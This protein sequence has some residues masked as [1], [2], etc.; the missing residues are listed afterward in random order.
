MSCQIIR[1]NEDVRSRKLETRGYVKR[2]NPRKDEWIQQTLPSDGLVLD[3]GCG[4]G[5]NAMLASEKGNRVIGI[6]ISS[7]NAQEA[8]DNGV[9]VAV[10]NVESHLPTKS[11][12]F[13]AVIFL[14]VVEHLFEPYQTLREIE[15]CL[16]PGG[17]LLI[18]TPNVTF[19]RNRILFL[20]GRPIFVDRNET[21]R[22]WEHEHIRFFTFRSIC[23]LLDKT[24][25][26]TVGVKGSFTRFP[27]ALA[28]FVFMPLNYFLLAF[29]KLVGSLEILRDRWPSVWAAGLW[30]EAHK[31]SGNTPKVE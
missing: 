5:Y 1:F 13:D 25:F 31:R 28:E 11:G 20:F 26:E 15:R 16:K 27:G 12:M 4:I 29:G 7:S 14:E 21:M 24:G 22:P 6:E 10:G 19:W 3:V 2:S 9:L 17:K 23:E 30:I 18:S 8:Q